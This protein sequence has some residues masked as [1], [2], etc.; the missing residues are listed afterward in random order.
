MQLDS[1]L[2]TLASEPRS[3]YGAALLWASARQ[4]GRVLPWNAAA[5][6]A[7]AKLSSS[8]EKAYEI[9]SLHSL[10]NNAIGLTSP[11]VLD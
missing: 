5:V 9:P 6:L 4:A 2:L 7:G 10:I 11:R 1:Q 8:C 3:G